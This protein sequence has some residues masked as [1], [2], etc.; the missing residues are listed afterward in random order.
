M[1]RTD[2]RFR[3]WFQ[4][5]CLSLA[6][7]LAYMPVRSAGLIWD[8]VFLVGAAVPPTL[9]AIWTTRLADNCPLTRTTFW[10]E[11]ILWG[12]NPLA[13]H[14]VDLVFH[15][16]CGLLLWQV[17]RRLR[18]P[19][20]WLGAALWALHPVQVESAAWIAETKNTQ[21]GVFFLLSLLFFLRLSPEMPIRRD[22]LKYGLMVLFAAL[23]MAS[24]A[25]T[26]VLPVLLCLCGWWMER[27]WNWRTVV[28]LAPVFALSLLSGI[29]TMWTTGLQVNGSHDRELH[30]EWIRSMPE[31]ILTAADAVWFYLYKLLW[32]LQIYTNYPHWNIDA[33][34]AIQWL[35]LFG[36]LATLAI[37]W[38]T[39]GL[40]S[41]FFAFAWFLIAL[42]PVLGLVEQPILRY[43]FVFD[44]FQ[45]LASMAPLAL[46]AAVL[47]TA[48][49]SVALRNSLAGVV[50]LILS[51][52]TWQRAHTFQNEEA[53]WSDT[54]AHNPGSWIAHNNLGNLLMLKGQRDNATDHFRHALE[55]NLNY[56]TARN[57]LGTVFA[58]E[59]RYADA[60]EQFKI[61]AELDPEDP[62]ARH[63]LES[64]QMVLQRAAA[65]G[66]ADP[67]VETH[68]HMSDGGGQ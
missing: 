45:Y 66:S 67:G 47:V 48:A 20:A 7:A 36:L 31:R 27:K 39:R 29:V 24:K 9:Q 8:D 55:L 41:Y 16:T 5:L 3:P 53:L 34:S 58:M 44:H 54:L 1:S 6:T 65:L 43:S 60:M 19:G 15:I 28:R 38:R 25:S 21:S 59:K 10:L 37:L 33:H 17:L 46:A 2:P 22:K 13:D 4:G 49:R 35:P 50:V 11:R 68:I 56:A 62:G 40:R 51:L 12:I 42:F 26:V 63:N 61:A 57:G 23:A 32:P 18:I 14:V 52:L 64:M 30:P